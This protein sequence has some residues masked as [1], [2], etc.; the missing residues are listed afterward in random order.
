M[1]HPACGSPPVIDPLF[2]VLAIIPPARAPHEH[3]VRLVIEDEEREFIVA[4]GRRGDNKN[5]EQGS[6]HLGVLTE[7]M[8]YL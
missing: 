5:Q 1:V 2:D 6:V 7:S 8:L 4:V 3:F